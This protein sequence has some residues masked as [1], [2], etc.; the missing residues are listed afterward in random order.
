M[1]LC[2]SVNGAPLSLPASTIIRI[3]S[4]ADLLLV[5]FGVHVQQPQNSV[6]GDGQEPNQGSKNL[7]M[8]LMRPDIPRASCSDFFMASRLGTSSPNTKVK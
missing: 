7:E 1:K 6:D 8:A 2:S 4:L 5:P 3:S